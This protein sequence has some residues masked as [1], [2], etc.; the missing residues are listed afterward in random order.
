MHDLFSNEK[1]KELATIYWNILLLILITFTAI[2]APLSLVFDY[3]IHSL[4]IIN[5]LINLIFISDLILSIKNNKYEFKHKN[6]YYRTWFLIDFLSAIPFEALLEF[7]FIHEDFELLKI[8]RILRLLR[9]IKIF[10]VN[11]SFNRNEFQ[12]QAQKRI[13]TLIYISALVA[14]WIAL[15]WTMVKDRVEDESQVTTYINSLYWTITTLTTIGYGDITPRTDNQKLFTIGIMI[16][17]A[18][19]YGYIIG[20]IANLLANID[21]AKTVFTEKMERIDTF[22]KYRKIPTT[23]KENIYD[24]YTYLWEKKKGYDEENIMDELPL[25]LRMKISLYLNAGIFDR[26]PIF[27]GASEGMIS[28]FVMRLKPVIFTPHDIIMKKGDRGD[29]MYF[30]SSG[31]VE[32]FDEST[33]ETIATLGE[34]AYFGEMALIDSSKRSAS[35]RA[36]DFCDLYSLEA[37]DFQE[38]ILEYP[39]FYEKIKI[40]AES[41]RRP[42]IN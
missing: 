13:I 21:Y 17:G 25:S 15:I 12:G 42:K 40:M 4:F 33:Q 34:G 31:R 1:L 29:C 18:G 2:E 19:M 39:E 7:G 38:V 23:L 3:S 20:N 27:A 6:S 24:Y 14:H 16:A 28:D 36:I 11:K 22:L 10:K 30:I 9:I 41:R 32:V 35:I 37:K 26:I 5:I 8:F